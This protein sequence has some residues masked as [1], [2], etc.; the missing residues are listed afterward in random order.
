MPLPRAVK[1]R[2]TYD[3][4]RKVPEHLVAELVDGELYTS[5]RPATLHSRA[6]SRLGAELDGPFDRGK[7]G[8]GGWIILDEPE[9]HL[10]SSIVVP[11]L[12]GWRR[13][14]MKEVPD[15]PAIDLP[16]DWICEVL[17]SSTEAFDRS[18]K[19]SH[20]AECRVQF[21]WLIEPRAR[22]LEVYRL[23]ETNWH[24]LSQHQGDTV[25]RAQPFEAIDFDMSILW[26]R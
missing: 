20:Y 1:R 11:D 19:M 22:T 15:A 2:A 12:A 5:P 26:A 25:I 13:E 21:S 23:K 24:L 18:M 9:L 3:D 8:P 17:S 6:A 4:L 16:P 7:N 10:G 14:R